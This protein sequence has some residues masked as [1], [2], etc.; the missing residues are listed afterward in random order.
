MYHLYFFMNIEMK[1]H[2]S[3]LVLFNVYL[4]I[5]IICRSKVI[6]KEFL[7]HKFKE[8]FYQDVITSSLSFILSIIR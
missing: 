2:S 4:E 8:M 5:R 7:I 6:V 1:Q 3:T